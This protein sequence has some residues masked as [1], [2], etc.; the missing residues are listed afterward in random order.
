MTTPLWW[1]D[2]DGTWARSL[3]RFYRLGPTAGPDDVRRMLELA[4]LCG[5]ED[6]A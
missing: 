6:D 3:S 2:P 4:G 5:S 1:A